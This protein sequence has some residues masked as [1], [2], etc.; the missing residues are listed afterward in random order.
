MDLLALDG[1]DNGL[2]VVTGEAGDYPEADH[3]MYTSCFNGSWLDEN[4]VSDS[5]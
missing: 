4:R 1:Y 5:Q 2:Q 3:M